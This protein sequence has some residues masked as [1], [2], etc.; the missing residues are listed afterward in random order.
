MSE[1]DVD[2]SL[3]PP[4]AEIAVLSYEPHSVGPRPRW[5]YAVAVVY[6]V[7]LCVILTL[8]GWGGLLLDGSI[9]NPA[10]C[11]IW[12]GVLAAVGLSLMVIP[13]RTVRRRVVTRR[14]IWLP[15]IGSGVFA[16]LLCVGAAAALCEYFRRTDSEMAWT[17]LAAG[18]LTWIAWSIVFALIAF[19]GREGVIGMTL[20]RWLIAGSVLEL[21]VAVP[22]HV[23]VRRRAD[24]CA[25]FWTG[26]G[27]CLGVAVMIVSFGPGVLLL[28]QRRRKQIAPPRGEAG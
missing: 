18:L 1:P 21:L 10:L 17:V 12:G 28:Y 9:Q 11:A 15:L 13:V 19:S 25:G 14:S 23:L 6:L 7:L 5:V 4:S 3:P 16:G 20:H 22:T 8:P 26:A 24:C 2:S 27:I